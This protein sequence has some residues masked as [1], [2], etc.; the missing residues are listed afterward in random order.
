[1]KERKKQ[2]GSEGRK[3]GRCVEDRK[4]GWL[5]ERRKCENGVSL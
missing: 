2:E 1:M 4:D 3:D 5:S